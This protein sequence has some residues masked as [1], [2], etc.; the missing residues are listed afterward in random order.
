MKFILLDGNSFCYRAFYAIRELSST[1]GE[2]TNA[3]Y[4]F[5]TMLEKVL[6]E[7]GPDGVAV[8]FDLKGP[9]FRHERYDQYKIQRSPMPED[10][11]LQMP[12]IKEV[13]EAMNIPI[14]E[15]SGFE[16][17]DVIATL[18]CLL[19]EKG[20][21]V[22]VVTGD[23]DM[24][25]IVSKRVK[26]LNPQKENFIYDIAAVKNRFGVG[27]EKITDIMALMGDASDNIPGVPGIGEKTAVKLI[28]E[29][30]SVEGVLK[31]LDEIKGD[32]LKE[33]LKNH[34]KDAFLS[35]ELAT[36]K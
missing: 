29:Y 10:L 25:Q 22:F 20:H 6:K 2:P 17:D 26:L 13:I 33:N 4:G 12:L 19:S 5:I 1:M 16:A 3:I 21:E 7:V 32:K 36:V 11:A 9:T 35:R 28:A 8:T 23:K 27:P 14:Y 31:N 15:K 18:S 34:Q 24:L 30:G